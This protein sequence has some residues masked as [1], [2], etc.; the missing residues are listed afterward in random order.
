VSLDAAEQRNI[1]EYLLGK[2]SQ[3]GLSPLEE[4]LLSDNDFYQELSIVEEEL[5]DDYLNGTFSES[6]RESFEKH[7]L[8][9]AERQRKLRFAR[10]LKKYVNDE[11][12]GLVRPSGNTVQ[13]VRQERKRFL[14]FGNPLLSYALA[15]AAVVVV[16]VAVWLVLTNN[17]ATSNSG[18]SLLTAVLT[19]G[20]VRESGQSNRITVSSGTKTVRLQLILAGKDYERYRAALSGDDGSEIWKADELGITNDN[21]R[22]M[23]QADVP[24]AVL[25][26]GDYKI[27]VSGKRQDSGIEDVAE[28]R[29][30]IIR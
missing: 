10:A 28:Y 14:G 23:V 7:F 4:R 13:V 6:E 26:A 3:D 20:Q 5:I 11:N 21:G 18:D 19:P 30:R 25:H 8:I 27:K 2:I 16:A 1:R 22:L 12:P 29:F 17:R 24:G 15:A 9:T